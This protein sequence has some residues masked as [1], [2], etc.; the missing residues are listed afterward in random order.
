MPKET[1][2]EPLGATVS[3]A[4]NCELILL[5]IYFFASGSLFP[6]SCAFQACFMDSYH[7]AGSS[8][9]LRHFAPC[10]QGSRRRGSLFPFNYAFR[11]CFTDSY[12]M[13]SSNCSLRRFAPCSQGSWLKLAVQQKHRSL[14]FV[15]SK[16]AYFL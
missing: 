10:S 12:H 6:F 3:E 9:S 13:A 15:L 16:Y 8:C 7:R 4:I 2:K 5:C 11:A 1:I 14:L